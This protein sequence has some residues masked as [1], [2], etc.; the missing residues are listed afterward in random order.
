MRRFAIEELSLPGLK[1][2]KRTK[3]GDERGFLTKLFSEEDLG[4]VGWNG[5]IKQVNHTFTQLKG[6]IRGMHFQYPPH[7]EMKLISCIRG[8]VWDVAVDLRNN[9]PTFLKWTAINLSSENLEAL[10]IPQGFAHGFQTL[11][12]DCE[13]IYLHSENYHAESEGAIRYNDPALDINWPLKRTNISLR[14][15]NH[16][17]V[18]PDFKGIL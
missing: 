1:K 15:Q 3:L 2:V 5:S 4:H 9:S 6:T 14:D 11:T 16:P 10:L 17:F 8:S 18:T 7:V 12:D 13:L